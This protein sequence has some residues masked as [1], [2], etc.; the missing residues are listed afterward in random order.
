MRLLSLW[1]WRPTVSTGA[2][3]VASPRAKRSTLPRSVNSQSLDVSVGSPAW[4]LIRLSHQRSNHEYFVYATA[5]A[6]DWVI[7]G[8][9]PDSRSSA[10]TYS[11]ARGGSLAAA[12]HT[13]TNADFEW[14]SRSACRRTNSRMYRW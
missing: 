8:C 3:D 5:P 9:H 12:P 6:K 4:R 11:W 14:L 7:V 1:R 2:N 13:E 10:S